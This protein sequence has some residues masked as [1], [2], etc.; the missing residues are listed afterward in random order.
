M[1]RT[2]SMSHGARLQVRLS[3]EQMQPLQRAAAITG[4]DAGTFMVEAA[5]EA[6]YRVL[7]HHGGILL[8]P[9]DQHAFVS[10]LLD[11]PKPNRRL[12]RAAKDY[13]AR[14]GG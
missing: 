13:L 8:A 6:A 3:G 5:L 11:P 9:T 7:A 10:A 1:P 2:A 12:K 4:C 14:S